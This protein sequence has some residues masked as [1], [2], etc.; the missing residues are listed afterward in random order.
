MPT[1][2]QKLARAEREM[3]QKK[4][5]IRGAYVFYIVAMTEVWVTIAR[6]GY[7]GAVWLGSAIVAT[8]VS[9]IV[10]AG[11]AVSLFGGFVI[12]LVVR[13]DC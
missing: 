13:P 6:Y 4:W 7:R 2:S 11:P 9:P 1:D 8:G 10:V 12:W 3:N 5:L